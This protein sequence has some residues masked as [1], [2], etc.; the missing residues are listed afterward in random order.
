M[1]WVINL[2]AAILKALGLYQKRYLTDALFWNAV[3]G[4]QVGYSNIAI[5][6][7]ESFTRI[8]VGATQLA[9]PKHNKYS[10]TVIIEFFN[11]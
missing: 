6:C 1:F 4:W 9:W 8:T 7:R 5:S 2:E 11:G 3:H 10:A